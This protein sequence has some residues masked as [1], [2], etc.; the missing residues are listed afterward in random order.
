MLKAICLTGIFGLVSMLLGVGCS[1]AHAAADSD[2]RVMTFNILYATAA[3]SVDENSWDHRKDLLIDTI[4]EFNPD[5]LG[6]QENTADQRRFMESKLTDYETFG[7]GVGD[8]K[9]KGVMNVIFFKKDRFT[10]LDGGHFWLSETP[11]VPGSKSWD[12]ASSRMATW[13]K[14]QD[15]D[16]PGKPILWFLNT[17]LD[18]KG[19]EARAQG[20]TRVLD[21]AKSLPAN[22]HIVMTGDFNAQPNTL[23]YQ[24]LFNNPAEAPLMKDAF[25][26][27]NAEVSPNERTYNGFVFGRVDG[28]YIDWIGISQTF[29]AKTTVVNRTSREERYPSDHWAVESVVSYLNR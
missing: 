6:T 12:T 13:V 4:T 26:D 21:W 25:R 17:H 3:N 22:S 5:L 9:Q 7:V 10:K 23:P 11:D 28:G 15:L 20:A 24:N 29:K 19:K 16:A 14:L 18:H 2:L 27:A 1:A 8:G